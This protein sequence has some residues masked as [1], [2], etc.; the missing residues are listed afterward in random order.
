MIWSWVVY[1]HV[2]V[3]ADG[4]DTA[5]NS[6]PQHTLLKVFASSYRAGEV[7]NSNKSG[8]LSVSRILVEVE[9]SLWMVSVASSYVETIPWPVVSATSFSSDTNP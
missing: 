1:I 3:E 4:A 7:W 2:H 5:T 9:R 6:N 8:L